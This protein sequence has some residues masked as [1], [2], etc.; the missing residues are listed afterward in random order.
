MYDLKRNPI[1]TFEGYTFKFIGDT[2]FGKRFVRGVPA[3]YMGYREINM[4]KEFAAHLREGAKCDYIVIIGDLFDS[5]R[6]SNETLYEI[7]KVL[8]SFLNR[9]TVK[10]KLIIIPGNH[11]LT[12]DKDKVSSYFILRTLLNNK[13]KDHPLF[14]MVFRE[15]LLISLDNLHIYVDAYDPFYEFAPSKGI[16]LIESIS[17]N[18]PLLSIG[19][20][21]DIRF[22]TG[23]VPSDA[24][25]NRSSYLVS[26]HIHIPSFYTVNNCSVMYVGSMQ[27]YSFGEDP[28]GLIYRI[29]HYSEMDELLKD[30]QKL[31]KE[32]LEHTFVRVDCYPGYNID[33][34]FGYRALLFNPIYDPP[35]KKEA[36][37][38]TENGLDLSDFNSIFLYTLKTEYDIEDDVLTSLD[39][40]LRGDEEEFKLSDELGDVFDE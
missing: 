13:F 20:W 29:Y 31:K 15:P 26:G 40:F 16:P 33:C 9:K 37:D 23:Y 3:K 21:D 24:I 8:Q 32:N 19:H 27:P 12:K 7:Y 30:P 39:K 25:I 6:V 5:I 35:V 10:A 1:L 17:D 38:E 36:A 11:D 4:V 2:H 14:T 28:D 18:I 22:N 34:W